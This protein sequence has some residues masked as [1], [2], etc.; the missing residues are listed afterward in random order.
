MTA[1]IR[2]A[3]ST[4]IYALGGTKIEQ[5]S[6]VGSGKSQE[7]SKL[8]N[9]Q[10]RIFGN[11]AHRN[12]IH[13]IVSWDSQSTRTIRHNDVLTLARDAKTFLF[14]YPHGSEMIYTGEL[15]HAYTINSISWVSISP[16]ESSAAL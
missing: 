11:S 14:Q 1:G 13:G 9:G 6:R 2:G 4:G 12:G 16:S 5:Q 7:F 15:W 10:P 3:G 8:L